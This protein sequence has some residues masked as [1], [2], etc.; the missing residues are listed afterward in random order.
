M[1]VPRTGLTTPQLV[2]VPALDGRPSAALQRG[3]SVLWINPMM[4]QKGLAPVLEIWS[5]IIAQIAVNVQPKQFST[6]RP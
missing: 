1:S 2:D 3:A 6:L 5:L 4:K